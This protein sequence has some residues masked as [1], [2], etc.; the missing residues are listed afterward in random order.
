MKLAVVFPGIGYH[1][2]KPLLYYTRKL[3]EQAGY[4]VLTLNYGDFGPLDGIRDDMEK[5]YKVF[6]RAWDKAEQALYNVDWSEPD[7]VLFISKSIGTTVAAAYED[8]HCVEAH[9]I[10]FTPIEQTFGFMRDESGIVFHGTKDA[11]AE[12]ESI[13]E[14]CR[15]RNVPVS[16]VDGANHSL[17]TGDID[18]D[19]R[20][21]EKVIGQ[22]EKYLQSIT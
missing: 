2:D 4:T 16:L 7:D 10:Y 18:Q 6:M 12:T 14:G 19:V 17:E 3:A 15:H 1:A 13:L 20:N 5:R 22:A 21:L 8:R 9:H 11:W